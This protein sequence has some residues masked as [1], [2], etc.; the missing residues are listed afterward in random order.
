MISLLMVIPWYQGV[1][2]I[3]ERVGLYNGSKANIELMSI[4][5]SLENLGIPDFSL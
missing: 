3:S 1:F 2:I 5:N 4:L